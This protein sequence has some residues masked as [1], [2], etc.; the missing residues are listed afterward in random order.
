[1]HQPDAPPFDEPWQAQVFALTVAVQEAGHFTWAEWTDTMA[2]VVTAEQDPQKPD[3][4]E[5][6]RCW[7]IAF[8]TLLERK[9]VADATTIAQ[10]TQAWHD[11]ALNTPHGQPISL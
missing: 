4:A 8:E 6:Y 1:M 3:Q 10:V 11:A 5:Y 2:E 7:M 9:G